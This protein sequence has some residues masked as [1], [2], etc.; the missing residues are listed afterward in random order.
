MFF[1]LAKYTVDVSNQNNVFFTHFKAAPASDEQ[2]SVIVDI[3]PTPP[4]TPREAAR[5]TFRDHSP[6]KLIY[7]CKHY[8][9]IS[10]P[11]S[12]LGFNVVSNGNLV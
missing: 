1:F 10:H 8:G 5:V 7:F 9:P 3:P 6:G 11:K 12:R 2:G 4:A